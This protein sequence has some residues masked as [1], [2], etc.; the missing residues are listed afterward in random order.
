MPSTFRWPASPAC[1]TRTVRISSAGKTFSAT[2][3]KIGWALGTPEL[4]TEITAVKQFLTYVSGAPFQPAVARA[5]NEGDG[6]V[7]AARVEL[8]GKRDRLAAGLSAIGLEPVLPRGTYFMTT[9]V[10]PLGY[11]RRGR[12]LPRP[13]AAL[14]RGRHSPPGLLRP[15]RGRPTVRPVGLLQVRPGA[16]R[17]DLAAEEARATLIR[18]LRRIKRVPPSFF[19]S[20]A[21]H[22][23]SRGGGRC[24]ASD[25]GR[26]RWTRLRPS[27]RLGRLEAWEAGDPATI[28]ATEAELLRRGFL[29]PGP[30]AGD[31]R[32]GSETIAAI[33]RFQYSIGA[34]HAYRDG[35]FGPHQW[36]TLLVLGIGCD[37]SGEVGHS[38]RRLGG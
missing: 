21:I 6:W 16:G 28:E 33:R 30:W 23:P 15:H 26:K 9:D 11:R 8:Q 2:G 7:A 10:R 38:A 37:D 12:V 24:P 4:I 20:V 3:W 17:G 22:C 25:P 13:A 34:G 36:T 1:G 35:Q 29:R 5:L 32:K 31:G 27:S 19:T 14:R 18:Q